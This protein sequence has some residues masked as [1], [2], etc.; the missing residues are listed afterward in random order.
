[1]I[2]SGE[3]CNK[4]KLNSNKRESRRVFNLTNCYRE[5]HLAHT[6]ILITFQFDVTNEI[7]DLDG[8]PRLGPTLK[9]RAKEGIVRSIGNS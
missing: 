9:G 5:N 3:K 7:S 4:K 8:K 2:N 6:Y 1:L